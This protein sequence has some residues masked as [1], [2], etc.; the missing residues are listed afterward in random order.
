MSKITKKKKNC[1]FYVVEIAQIT[2]IVTSFCERFVVKLVVAL[3][4]F[5][6]S[7]ATIYFFSFCVIEQIMNHETG[8]TR[9]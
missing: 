3:E 1:L 6:R 4:F 8:W 9:K 5:I 2:L 7:L